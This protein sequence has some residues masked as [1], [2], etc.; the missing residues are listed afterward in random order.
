MWQDHAACKGKPTE[1][2]FPISSKT[3]CSE[4]KR[5]CRECPVRVDCVLFAMKH[6]LYGIWGGMTESERAEWSRRVKPKT[7]RRP[8]QNRYE[9]LSL[10]GRKKPKDDPSDLAT[11]QARV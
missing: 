7:N 5:I 10:R 2:F 4:A 1:L 9:V 11:I 6:D 3:D 8:G